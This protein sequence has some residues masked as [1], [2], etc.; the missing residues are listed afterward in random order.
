MRFKKLIK[1]FLVNRFVCLFGEA[2]EYG[3]W[4]YI[5]NNYRQ[6]YQI[7]PS[8]KFN[9]VGIQLYGDGSGQI[10]LGSD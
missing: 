3:R 4:E 5:Y 7:S 6:R 10:I 8:F 1:P 9:G 2:V